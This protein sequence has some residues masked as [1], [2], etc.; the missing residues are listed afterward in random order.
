MR[1]K[2][3]AEKRPREVKMRV[4]AAWG[5]PRKAWGSF[6]TTTVLM[7]VLVWDAALIISFSN[8]Y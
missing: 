7:C 5:A 3:V 2:G 6:L 4:G 8:L 1:A